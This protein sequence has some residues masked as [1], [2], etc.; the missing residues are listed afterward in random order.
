MSDG[1]VNDGRGERGPDDNP[2][3]LYYPTS[4]EMMLT[5]NTAAAT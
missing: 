2:Q 3:L 5:A 1:R 4:S